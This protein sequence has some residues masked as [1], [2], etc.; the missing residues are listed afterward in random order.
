MLRRF[1]TV[2]EFDK[3]LLLAAATRPPAPAPK[4]RGRRPAPRRPL[5]FVEQAHIRINS[6]KRLTLLPL[7]LPLD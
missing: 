2:L 4:P 5:P 6:N 1:L 7:L 3:A